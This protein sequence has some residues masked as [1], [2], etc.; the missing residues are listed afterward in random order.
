MVAHRTCPTNLLQCPIEK[1][2]LLVNGRIMSNENLFVVKPEESHENLL[3]HFLIE[4]NDTTSLN[5]KT[6]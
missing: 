3:I 1:R 6:E 2:F 5:L 4:S